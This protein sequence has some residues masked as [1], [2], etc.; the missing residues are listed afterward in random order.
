MSERARQVDF[1]PEGATPEGAKAEPP[2][3]KPRARRQMAQR[4]RPR[5]RPREAGVDLAI[6][7]AGGANKLAAML[8]INQSAVSNWEQVPKKHA[9]PIARL[10]GLTLH[11]LRP[12]LYPPNAKPRRPGRPLGG[13]R[14]PP[15]GPASA[16]AVQAAATQAI[17]AYEAGLTLCLLALE[18]RLP[19]P[20]PTKPATAALLYALAELKRPVSPPETLSGQMSRA[21]WLVRDVPEL[22]PLVLAGSMTWEAAGLTAANRRL[23]PAVYNYIP[24]S[25]DNQ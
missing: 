1:F 17:N 21:R 19:D 10:L 3:G 8:G 18:G 14:A 13:T 12:D 25:P 15:A 23:S 2:A 24:G 7:A 5:E 6:A 9:V 4:G 22:A 16:A 11:Q 20:M